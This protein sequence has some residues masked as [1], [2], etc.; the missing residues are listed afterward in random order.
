MVQVKGRWTMRY[1]SKHTASRC[2]LPY[3]LV[4]LANSR[5]RFGGVE[6]KEGRKEAGVGG[7]AYNKFEG[8]DPSSRHPSLPP[9]IVPPT[10]IQTFQ[11]AAVHDGTPEGHLTGVLPMHLGREKEGKDRWLVTSLGSLHQTLYWWFKKRKRLYSVG[12]SWMA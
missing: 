11:V 3:C 10:L 12:I 8:D 1:Q 9:P 4:R 2:L 5:K 7:R 6:E